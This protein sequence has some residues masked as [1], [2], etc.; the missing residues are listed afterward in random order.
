M[1]AHPAFVTS[2]EA[3]FIAGVTDRE[4]NRVID[5]HIVPAP[6][7]ERNNGRRVARLG[8]AL[9]SFYF[10][11]EPL[12]T[13]Q[14]RRQTL[15]VVTARVRASER[16]SQALPLNEDAFDEGARKRLLTVQPDETPYLLVDLSPFVLGATARARE[17]DQALEHVNV[18]PETMSGA[19][20]FKGTR[21]E[22]ETVLASL[23]S[24]VELARLQ[25]SYSF[26]TPEL[27]NAARVYAQ[28]RPRRGRPRRLSEAHPDWTVKSSKV[29]RPP[30]S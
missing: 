10:E 4:V 18:D 15:A 19:P 30:R 12:F 14:L 2:A 20:V 1:T 23:D 29:V 6:L 17:V 5:E 11:T 28:V 8:A 26:L 3:A 25:K 24:G 21:L 16:W 7:L 13:A 27:V 9:I 22:I